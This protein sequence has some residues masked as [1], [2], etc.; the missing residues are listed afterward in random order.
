MVPDG[1]ANADRSDGNRSPK[2]A[3]A[4][5][6]V[7]G[8]AAVAA[9][10]AGA[11]GMLRSAGDAAAYGAGVA[12]LPLAGYTAVLVANTAVPAWQ[13]ASHTLPR[14]FLGSAMA[15]TAA[16]LQVRPL[17][18]PEETRAAQVLEMAGLFLSVMSRRRARPPRLLTAAL[19]TAAALALRFAV[20]HLGK[21][22]ARDPRA[23]FHQQRAGHG[24]AAVTGQSAIVGASGQRA[25]DGTTGDPVATTMPAS[26]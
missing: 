17:S 9:P 12:G 10:L 26:D 25:T 7:G 23:T 16:L 19:G 22:S 15:A 24:A 3:W 20:F 2:G 4:L 21:A 13:E 11:S 5:A 8:T 18:D 14:L 6:A 1:S